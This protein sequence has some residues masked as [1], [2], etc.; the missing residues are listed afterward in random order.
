MKR[1]LLLI[2][3][4]LSAL[5][6]LA[7]GDEIPRE[8]AI[9]AAQT[10]LGTRPLSYTYG[11]GAETTNSNLGCTSAPSGDLG[12]PVLPYRYTLSYAQGNYVVYASS[13][14]TVTVL[15]DAQFTLPPTTPTVTPSGVT[16]S[17]TVTPGA[18]IDGCFLSSIGAFTNV[19][20]TPSVTG[21]QV[22]TIYS[23]QVYPI[24]ARNTNTTDAWYFLSAGWVNAQVIT[25]TG[26]C[27]TLP[28]DDNRVGS[29]IGL[30]TPTGDKNIAQVLQTYACPADFA[31]YLVPQ[32]RVGSATA[33][34]GAG[35]VPNVIRSAPVANDS[36]GARLGT[37]QPNRT[38]DRVINGPACSG[39]YVWWLVEADGT[40]G[41]TVES[42][43]A[44]EEYYLEPTVG[45]EVTGTITL[46]M[47]P[48]NS[49]YVLL[50]KRDDTTGA[51]FVTLSADGLFALAGDVIVGANGEETHVVAEY[52]LDK[53]SPTFTDTGIALA[54]EVSGLQ[55]LRDGTIAVSDATNISLFK[56]EG[57]Q[58]VQGNVFSN[59][60]GEEDSV[61]AWSFNSD[62]R[63]YAYVCCVV[64][65]ITTAPIQLIL[66]SVT[67]PDP[68]WIAEL[69]SEFV[70]FKVLFSPDAQTVAVLGFDGVYL[71]DS[72]TGIQQAVL[73][74]ATDTF[75]M[76]DMAF[77]PKDSTRL[78]TSICKTVDS[79][80]DPAPC[81]SGELTLWSLVDNQAIGVV[82]TNNANPLHLLYSSDGER[83][84][85]GD[86]SGQVVVRDAQGTLLSTLSVVTS[87]GAP[88]SVVDMAL[89]A[90][91]TSIVV[92]NSDGALVWFTTGE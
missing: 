59:L 11:I 77:D 6:I 89:N 29:G 50:E 4:T 31:G 33:K 60:F 22:G 67:S 84:F 66:R 75:G 8:A 38:I 26:T 58:Y 52:T 51:T 87:D 64:P 12:R 1:F 21:A 82:Q 30:L 69:P 65:N 15:C 54:S 79:T 53:T 62:G 10:V 92:S 41:W 68:L 91:A 73:S 44:Q 25:L 88:V 57:D 47:T 34:V 35:G 3:L 17:V 61:R 45:N 42:D 76:L 13:D 56:K 80:Q 71:F 40:Q 39:G 36:I 20:A 81:N 46:P 43:V 90:F 28:A 2:L 32:I 14:G 19:R 7:Q 74:N 55:T 5:P 48:I 83:I 63:L 49:D 37:I 9:Q 24:V 23:G 85:V 72:I 86:A 18:P 16:P 27:N 70:P 78:L